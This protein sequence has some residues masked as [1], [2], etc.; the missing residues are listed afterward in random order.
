MKTKELIGKTITTI[1]VSLDKRSLVIATANSGKYEFRHIQDCCEDV[2]IE[3]ICGDLG[4]L[5][6]KPLLVA[7]KRSSSPDEA[8]NIGEQEHWTWTFYRFATI[9]GT[10]IVRWFGTSNG[11]YSE[12][13]SF[14]KL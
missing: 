5:I 4:D 13:V 11:C 14:T 9:K 7:D 8:P 3:D 10:V 12:E 2:Y 6:G 1:K